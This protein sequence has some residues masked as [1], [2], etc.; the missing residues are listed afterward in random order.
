MQGRIWTSAVN[1][2]YINRFQRTPPIF[3]NFLESTF[4][5]GRIW[6]SILNLPYTNRFKGTP[7][8]NFLESTALL[9]EGAAGGLEAGADSE[10]PAESAAGGSE[11]S[12]LKS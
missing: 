9:P 4:M 12:V 3:S 8:S 7:H 5:Q 1:L 6:T 2:P 11:A 10:G